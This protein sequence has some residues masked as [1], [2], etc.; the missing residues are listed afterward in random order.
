LMN[1][2]ARLTQLYG[3]SAKLTLENG[4]NGGAV[5]TM[6]L[7]YQIAHEIPEAQPNAVDHANR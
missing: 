3:E 2:R 4:K 7:P 1:T 5:A 6:I